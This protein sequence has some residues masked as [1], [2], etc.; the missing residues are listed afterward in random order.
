MV[1]PQ[2][3]SHRSRLVAL[4]LCLLFGVFGAHRF[5]VRKTGTAVLMLLTFGG[6]MIWAMIDLIFIVLG[7]F[8][9]KEGKR[10][11]RWF[12]EGSI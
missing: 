11:L 12:E 8:R 2:E 9:D 4:F 1:E 7:S 10:I 3:I 5:Y 6:F